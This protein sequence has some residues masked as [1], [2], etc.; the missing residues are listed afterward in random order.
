VAVGGLLIKSNYAA[1][2]FL[3]PTGKNSFFKK[4][5]KL[6]RPPFKQLVKRRLLLLLCGLMRA[7][8]EVGK[9]WHSVRFS[10]T[11]L[12]GVFHFWIIFPQ[13]MLGR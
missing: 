8:K 6:K 9:L 3:R 13:K 12:Q 1:V 5:R 7:L 2:N 10:A 4:R 11:L